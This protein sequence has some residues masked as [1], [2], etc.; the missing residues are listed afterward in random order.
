LQKSLKRQWLDLE[1]W[2]VEGPFVPLI[3]TPATI[4]DEAVLTIHFKIVNSTDMPLKLRTMKLFVT[5]R[6]QYSTIRM[7]LTPNAGIPRD[8]PITLRKE[9]ADLYG[10]NRLVLNIFGIISYIDAFGERQQQSFGK[11][12]QCGPGSFYFSEFDGWLPDQ[13]EEEDEGEAS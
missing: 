5:G 11:V 9:E 1:G 8:W 12:C 2:K 6:D 4:P 7:G 13:D 10:E 3:K